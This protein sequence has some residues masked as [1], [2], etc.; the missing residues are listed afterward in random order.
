MQ[1]ITASLEIAAPPAKV[2][3]ILT[4]IDAWHEWSPTINASSGTA[5]VGSTP[6]ITMMS[7]A[8]GK[9]GPKYNPE[10]IKLEEP[11]YFHWRARMLAGFLFTNDKIITLEETATGTRLTHTE[12]FSGMLS[13]L[14]CGQMEKGVP[15]M[16]DAMNTALKELA[17]K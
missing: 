1:E 16:L 12:T 13:K 3:A 11:S 17:E 2:W 5:A 6:S 9:D 7:N 15:P 14:F 8:E 10:I 4:N